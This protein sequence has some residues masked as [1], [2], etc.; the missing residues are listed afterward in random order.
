MDGFKDLA[1]DLEASYVVTDLTE[2]LKAKFSLRYEPTCP[3]A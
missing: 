3:P 2:D 1:R